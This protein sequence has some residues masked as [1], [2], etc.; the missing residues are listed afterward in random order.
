MPRATRSSF[1]QL[2]EDNL[3]RLA[4]PVALSATIA[5]LE[6][7]GLLSESAAED[8]R[9]ELPE[10]LEKSAYVL[11]HLAAHLA[12]GAIFAFDLIPLPLGTIGRV[13]WVMGNR[14]YE[15]TLG[16]RERARVH[17]LGVLGIAAIPWLGYA[18]YLLP[19]RRASDEAAY[20]YANHLSYTRRGSAA[21][22]LL[23]TKPPFVRRMASWLIPSLAKADLRG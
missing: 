9:C 4:D 11:R 21:E 13:L 22:T 10:T 8:L 2:F 1:R 5:R 18:A 15:S 17:S 23:A 7:D 14:F 6:A 19:L 3:S 20:L 16:T 12:I